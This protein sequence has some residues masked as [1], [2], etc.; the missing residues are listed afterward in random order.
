M[1]NKTTD[2]GALG[3]MAS[4]PSTLI[5]L[6]RWRACS[7]PHRTAYS[8]LVDGETEKLDVTYAELDRQA[9]VIG[10]WLEVNGFSGKQVLLLYPPGIDYIAAFFGCLYAGA[11]AVP[12]Y[13]PR[14]NRS[15]SRLETLAVDSQ[16]VVALTTSHTL[17]RVRPL[18]Q[19]HPIL[20]SLRWQDTTNIAPDLAQRWQQPAVSG[21]A[22]AFLQYTSG[23]TA[24]PK[25]VMV[26]HSNLLCN[27]RM[28][29]KTFGQSEQ[30]VIVSWLPLYHDMG[31]IGGV[32]QPLYLGAAC[33]L[34][35]PMSFLQRP[36]RMAPG[37]FALQGDH[38]RRAGFCIRPL[39]AKNQPST[40]RDA[41]SEQLDCS[42]QRLRARPRG[43]P[44]RVRAR[45]S[46][47]RFSP[48][49]FLPLLWTGRSHAARIWQI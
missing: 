44:G 2:T 8:F 11:I 31:L 9:R 22:L 46:I 42:L 16:S 14:L 20:K 48:E 47:Q 41:R 18:L 33:I 3:E 24:A 12:A 34:M 19:E 35:S 40:E 6:L 36:F 25:G 28:I 37:D 30:S 39:P 1:L 38:Q 29:K 23:S 15:L 5:E 32:L 13:P 26:S 27:Q 7:Q 4:E 49:L 43:D 10:G 21:D 17:L 45:F